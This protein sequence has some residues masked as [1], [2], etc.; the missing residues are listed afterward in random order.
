MVKKLLLCICWIVNGL[1]P[2]ECW[3]EAKQLFSIKQHDQITIQKKDT[4]NNRLLIKNLR[5]EKFLYVME[6]LDLLEQTFCL[7][8]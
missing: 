3:E 2:Q 4:F 8:L 7:F 1:Y 6:C 5:A